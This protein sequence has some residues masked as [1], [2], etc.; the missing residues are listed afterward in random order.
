MVNAVNQNAD[1]IV[2]ATCQGLRNAVANAARSGVS[3]SGSCALNSP[4][5]VPAGNGR[6]LAAARPPFTGSC[7]P[8]Q[9]SSKLAAGCLPVELLH[10]VCMAVHFAAPYQCAWPADPRA[11]KCTCIIKLVKCK[12]C[13]VAACR[14]CSDVKAFIQAGCSCDA[15]IQNLATTLLGYNQNTLKACECPMGF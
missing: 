5:C 15:Q 7:A 8:G 11:L 14:C 13:C 2:S 10:R 4:V 9:Y 3:P 1:N 6:Y 12:L